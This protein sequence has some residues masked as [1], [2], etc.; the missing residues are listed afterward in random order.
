MTRP[1]KVSQAAQR[2]RISPA[3]TQMHCTDRP[4]ANDALTIK[5][6]HLMEARLKVSNKPGGTPN[7]EYMILR[8]VGFKSGQKSEIVALGYS[9][10]YRRHW[11]SPQKTEL[12]QLAE[13]AT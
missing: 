11:K 9:A 8:T 1:L 5:P 2:P 7:L 6:D 10:R 12:V 4:V 3:G 13:G